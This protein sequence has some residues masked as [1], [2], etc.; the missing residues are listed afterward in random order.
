MWAPKYRRWILTRDLKDFARRC[1]NEIAASNDLEMEE[2]EIAE[3]HVQIFLGFPPKYS[4]ATFIFQA[5]EG[6]FARAI[7]QNYAE[8]QRK[9]WEGEC[10]EDGYLARTLGDKV[11]KDMIKSYINYHKN[12]ERT[13][14]Q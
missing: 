1:M 10:W 4:V 8:V 11:T 5:A 7:A 12:F 9:S 2:A 3:D 13:P 6:A 14:K